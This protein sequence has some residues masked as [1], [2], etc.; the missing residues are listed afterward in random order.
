MCAIEFVF[1]L[2]LGVLFF[3]HELK[4]GRPALFRIN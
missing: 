1:Y 3:C 2:V 4:V